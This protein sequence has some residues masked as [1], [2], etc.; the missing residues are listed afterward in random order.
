VQ[1][2]LD[3]EAAYERTKEEGQKWSGVMRRVREAEHLSFPLQPEVR[4]GTK[5]GGE[6]ISGFKP[7]NEMESAVQALLDKANLT[8]EKGM[9]AHEDA[10]L[11]GQ[12]L[13]VEEIAKRRADL[14][15]QR[16][17]M[18]RAEKRAKRV[19]KIK[20]KTFRKLARKRAEKEGVS[21]EDLE[22]LDPEAAEM[23]REKIEMMRARERATQRHGARNKF[24]KDAL[25]GDFGNDD[26]R[27][28]REE[29]LDLKERLA[30][31][32]AGRE[33]GESSD[34][35][36]SSEGEGEEGEG[37][38]KERAFDQLAALEAAE[39]AERAEQGGK[40]GLMRMAFMQRARERDMQRVREDEEALRRDIEMFGEEGAAGEGGGGGGSG[41]EDEDEDE[42]QVMRL[43]EGRMVFGGPTVSSHIPV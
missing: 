19:A 26:R 7:A 30:R 21:V 28:A 35:D 9:T 18:F 42:A 33:E 24:G 32:I 6:V 1:D 37:G 11:Q 20:S 13:S 36:E 27:Q 41:S 10:Q 22:R 17:L 15:Y 14:R 39:R 25:R 40:K 12:D 8:S 38:V 34:D 4:G 23:Q 29:M 3:R 31:K 16:E 2:R 5:S 43:G